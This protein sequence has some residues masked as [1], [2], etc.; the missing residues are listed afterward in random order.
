[1]HLADEVAT[2]SK[3][4]ADLEA[5]MVEATKLRTE[6][7]ATNK[8]TVE[9]S[10][11]AQGAVAAATAVLKTFYEKAAMATGLLQVDV[12]RPKMG[13]DEW[14]ALANPNFEPTGAGYGQGSEDKV[15][16]GHKAGMQ[17]FGKTYQGQQDE[18]GGVFAM[19]EVISSDFQ[20]LKADTESNEATAQQTYDDFMADSKKQLAVNDKEIEMLTNDKETSTADKMT[21]TKDLKATQDQLL[22]AD[23]Y[24][25]K[26]KPTCVDS[27]VSYA[28]RVKARAEEIQSLKEALKILEGSGVA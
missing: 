26:L 20:T 7:K 27:G 14:K 1:M 15:D 24:Y 12:S 9:D 23:R 17:T 25:E 5:S 28:D 18:A 4:V 6:E 19:L 2:L 11:A 21:D 10:Q 13:T 3:E 22:A 16:K 8:V